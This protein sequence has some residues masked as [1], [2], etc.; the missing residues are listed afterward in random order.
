MLR[1]ILSLVFLSLVCSAFSLTALHVSPQEVDPGLDAELLLE[2]TQGIEDIAEVNIQYRVSGESD[3]LSEPMQKDHEESLYFRGIIPRQILTEAEIEYRFQLKMQTGGIGYLPPDDGMTPL[4]FLRPNA[5]TGTKTDAF[6]LLTDESSISAGDG[7]VL[8]VSFMALEDEIDPETIKVY[9]G[10]KDVTKR[11]QI[12]GSVLMYREDRPRAGLQ[13]A[14][15]V[16]EVKGKEVY[17]ETWVTQ[18]L[19]GSSRPGLPFTV[20]GAVNFSANVTGSSDSLAFG[21]GDDD[22]RSWA[23]V[24]G[25]YGILDLQAKLLVSSLEDSNKQPVNRYS[26]GLK[27]PALDI[28]AGDYSPHLSSYTLSGKN[29]RGLYAHL[30]GKYAALTW[31]HGES[32]RKTTIE[33][34]GNLGSKS[35]TFK[36]EAIGAR[37][38][39][40]NENSFMLGFA[41]SRHRDIV[42]SLDEEYYRYTEAK[43]DTVYTARAQDNAVISLEARLNV[44]DQHVLMGVEVAGSMLNTNTIPGPLSSAELE[45]YGL[46]LEMG[47][48]EVN[49]EDYAELFV[50]NK[51]MEP[52]MPGRANL[53]WTA[54]L[55]MYFWNNFLTLEYNETGTAFNALGTYSRFCDSKSLTVTDQITVGRILVLSGS[56]SSVEDNLMG[57]KSE[58]NIYQNINAQAILRIPDLPYLKASFSDNLGENK[59]N[60]DIQS[61][62]EPYNRDSRA[63]SFGIGYNVVQIPYVPS[64]FDISY[65]MGDDSSERDPGTGMQ[66]QSENENSGLSFSMNNRF[67]IIPLR[68]RFTYSAAKNENFIL[69]QE[70]KNNSIYFKADYSFLNNLI[71][72]YVSYRNTSLKGDYDPQTYNYYNLGV[73]AFPI[74]NMTVTADLGLRNYA[75]DSDS[76]QDYD[77]TT[78]RLLLTQRF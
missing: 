33:G 41:G 32:V 70:Y 75:N 63:M 13:K 37:L 69:D 49:P 76:S 68:T 73:E 74:K 54:Y 59:I 28:Y 29:I 3:W 26:F 44:P 53:A 31:A 17:S 56:Y 66:I 51:N 5:Q 45:D 77:T 24:Y 7:Y 50:I 78:F 46:N 18:I 9:V 19:P 22:Y 42:S 8:A 62:F 27:L 58:T 60:D 23:D 16:A 2:I 4:Y 12:S 35:G 10:G 21:S 64:Q 71:K 36:Q 65:R 55:R 47:S 20:R 52:F 11:T 38:R 15:V 30:H 39:L 34:D 40:G 43:G 61:D 25:N 57:Y 67:N 14:M 48:I 1:S 72:P 6:V